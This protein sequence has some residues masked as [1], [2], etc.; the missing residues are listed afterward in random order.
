M[1]AGGHWQNEPMTQPGDE[2]VWV[3]SCIRETLSTCRV[4]QHGFAGSIGY[5][6]TEG[7]NGR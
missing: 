2:E 3:Q 7:H 6:Q 4:E 1:S 5:V